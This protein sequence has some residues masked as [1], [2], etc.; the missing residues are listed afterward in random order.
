MPRIATVESA[1]IAGTEAIVGI[2]AIVETAA[3]EEIRI[4]VTDGDIAVAE[5]AD[6]AARAA[7]SSSNS[8]RSS[9]FRS[10]PPAR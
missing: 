6:P 10:P 3:T 5:D 8:S 4:D 9:P 1:A 2:E 7:N